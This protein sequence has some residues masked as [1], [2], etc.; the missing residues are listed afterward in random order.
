MGAFLTF[1]PCTLS[2]STRLGSRTW[3][4]VWNIVPQVGLMFVA[5][6]PSFSSHRGYQDILTL[7]HA[8]C[9]ILSMAF[10]VTMEIVQLQYGEQ[11]FTNF[12]AK[13][14]IPSG[15]SQ[16]EWGGNHFP[17][18]MGMGPLELTANQRWRVV[19]SVYA[20]IAI[21]VFLSVQVCFGLFNDR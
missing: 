5:V 1:C 10:M 19:L 7:I 16:D 12:F 13:A 15:W 6:I 14:W 8:A 11:A 9:A 4:I 3:S 18:N 2:N 20:V 17:L 21:L